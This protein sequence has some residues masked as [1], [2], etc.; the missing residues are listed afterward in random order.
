MLSW[1]AWGL[2]IL[3]IRYAIERHQQKIAAREV[4]DALNDTSNA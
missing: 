1:L 2:L 4:Q 3:G